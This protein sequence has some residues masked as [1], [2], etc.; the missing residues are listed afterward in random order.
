MIQQKVNCNHKYSFI[1]FTILVACTLD[2]YRTIVA[3]FL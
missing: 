1:S 3:F 2:A